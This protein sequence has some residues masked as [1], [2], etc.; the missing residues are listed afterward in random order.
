[1]LLNLL[2]ILLKKEKLKK[3]NEEK[4]KSLDKNLF[5]GKIIFEDINFAYPSKP[6]NVILKNFNLI[7]T[8]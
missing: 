1:M 4:E 8:L 2:V 7:Y 5:K 6:N 3:E